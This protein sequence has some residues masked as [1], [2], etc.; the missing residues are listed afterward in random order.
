VKF[1]V[2][3]LKFIGLNDREVRVFTALSTFGRMNMTK[4]SSRAGLS[5]TT[6]DAIVR[7]LV[8][9][10]FI[11]C[12]RVGGHFEYS[13]QLDEVAQK[14]E[15]L[16]QR[17]R[18]VALAAESSTPAAAVPVVQA[19]QLTNVG[20]LPEHP[21][22]GA[23]VSPETSIQGHEALDELV[24]DMFQAHRGDRATLLVATLL[25]GEKR[26]E[27]FA[28][29]LT[30]ARDSSV[31]LEVLATTDVARSLSLHAPGILRLLP[32]YDIRLNFLPPSFCIEHTDILA[33]RDRVLVVDHR[34]E[35][36]ESIDSARV[37]ATINH[38]LRVSREA[39][40]GMDLRMWLE[41][42]VAAEGA[43]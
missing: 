2:D 31:L 10:G 8:G 33:F 36:V 9:Q 32:E 25:T 11:T 22:L 29:C 37:V 35:A 23:A 24:H 19:V 34:V 39:G 41:S 17:L 20:E 38:L 16:L 15:W 40:W 5:R 27:R 3:Q 28:H 21:S 13:V 30:R 6:V 14:L 26:Y 18:P 7:R 42:V 1:L 4:I 12:E 43:Q